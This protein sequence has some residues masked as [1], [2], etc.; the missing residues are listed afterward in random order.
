MLGKDLSII[1]RNV[2]A[3]WHTSKEICLEV[4]PEETQVYIFVSSP[5]QD[6]S[7]KLANKLFEN[8]IKFEYLEMT[9][10]KMKIFTRTLRAVLIQ[11]MFSS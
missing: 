11:E 4:N 2:E 7:V 6:C 9:K 3:V 1:E 5:E 10:T 8:I